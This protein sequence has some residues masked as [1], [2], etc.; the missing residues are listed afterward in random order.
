MRAVGTVTLKLQRRM[1]SIGNN[2]FPGPISKGLPRPEMR[3]WLLGVGL[4]GFKGGVGGRPK[5][6]HSSRDPW[7]RGLGWKRW[8]WPLCGGLIRALLFAIF[9]PWIAKCLNRKLAW[10]LGLSLCHE[11]A[12]A[13]VGTQSPSP[14]C[15]YWWQEGNCWQTRGATEE[16]ASYIPE[17]WPSKKGCWQE[18]SN[19]FCGPLP[20]LERSGQEHRRQSTNCRTWI[21]AALHSLVI[22]CPIYLCVV[23]KFESF[24]MSS[25]TDLSHIKDSFHSFLLTLQDVWPDQNGGVSVQRSV[26]GW[27]ARGKKDVLGTL[28]SSLGLCICWCFLWPLGLM[29]LPNLRMLSHSLNKTFPLDVNSPYL[30][31]PILLQPRLRIASEGRVPGGAYVRWRQMVGLSGLSVWLSSE[32]VKWLLGLYVHY[33]D[34]VGLCKCV[35]CGWWVCMCVRV[36]AGDCGCVC[37]KVILA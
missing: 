22:V 16:L 24:K 26:G 3:S 13:V 37:F 35:S 2:R 36:N 8:R 21:Q 27:G 31:P 4:K 30:P 18:N 23:I 28:R 5:R 29:H 15:F 32:S 25:A 14:C 1:P 20:L 11:G 9:W 6:E 34:L 19:G 33:H 10:F 17:S 7:V 12:W